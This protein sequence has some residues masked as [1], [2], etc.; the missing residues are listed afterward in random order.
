MVILGLTMA[1]ASTQAVASATIATVN[2]M[3]I[4]EADANKALNTLTKGQ[5]KWSTLP[6]DARKQLIQMMAPSKLVLAKAKKSLSTKE[7]DAAV[8]SFWMQKSMANIKITDKEAKSAYNK[9]KKNLKATKS[10]QKLP[11]FDVAKNSI[12]MQL[13]QEKVVAKLMKSAKIKI[14]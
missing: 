11:A 2:G 9:M 3:K 4:T 7:R 5:K 13:A 12:K 14:K 1:L 10:T 6:A 8:S